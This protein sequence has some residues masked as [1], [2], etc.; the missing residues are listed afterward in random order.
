MSEIKD[1]VKIATATV[2]LNDPEI[3]QSDDEDDDEKLNTDMKGINLNDDPAKKKKKKKKKKKT[4]SA[5]TTSTSISNGGQQQ[6]KP[7]KAQTSP[8]TIPVCELFIDSNYPLGEILDYPIP[9]DVD[10]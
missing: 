3:Q 4:D 10:G 6:P 7:S 2:P 1:D 8:P 9:K 5:V